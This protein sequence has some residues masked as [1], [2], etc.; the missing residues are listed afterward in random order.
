MC[1]QTSIFLFLTFVSLV[2][3]RGIN[4]VIACGYQGY[5]VNRTF[6]LFEKIIF[7]F[8]IYVVNRSIRRIQEEFKVAIWYV[9][10][11]ILPEVYIEAPSFG[12]KIVT[13]FHELPPFIRNFKAVRYGSNDR[14][15]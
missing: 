8:G 9:N 5:L 11:I 14:M 12:V 3:I 2:F 4:E 7:K 6:N 1:W 10:T 13:H 15:I